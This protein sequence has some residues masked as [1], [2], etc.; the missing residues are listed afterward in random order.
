MLGNVRFIHTF[1]IMPAEEESP[2]QVNDR[3]LGNWN[4]RW[5]FLSLS[6]CG[7]FFSMTTSIY[8][9]HLP[10]RALIHVGGNHQ[11]NVVYFT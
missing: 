4:F 7:M 2:T 3:G 11:T 10:F 5:S 9:C 1:I 6:E 8:F